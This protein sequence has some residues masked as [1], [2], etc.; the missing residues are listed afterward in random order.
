MH[1][2]ASSR[3]IMKTLKRISICHE[4]GKM[5]LPWLWRQR[6][7]TDRMKHCWNSLI[8]DKSRFND[9]VWQWTLGASQQFPTNPVSFVSIFSHVR[10]WSPDLVQTKAEYFQSFGFLFVFPHLNSMQRVL[11]KTVLERLEFSCFQ[12]LSTIMLGCIRVSQIQQVGL[13]QNVE[14]GTPTRINSKLTSLWAKT[15]GRR[16]SSAWITQNSGNIYNIYS[17]RWRIITKI[18]RLSTALHCELR[19]FM[20]KKFLITLCANL[21]T[22]KAPSTLS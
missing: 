15:S 11:D 20:H 9:V 14:V 7:C 5:A 10:R 17:P 16:C 6:C 3:C 19:D 8:G 18:Q 2:E 1:A 12:G 21:T 4:A 22:A 13:L